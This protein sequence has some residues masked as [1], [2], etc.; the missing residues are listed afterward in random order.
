[1]INETRMNKGLAEALGFRPNPSYSEPSRR[2][3]C[4][5]PGCLFRTD[6]RL[7]LSEH[8]REKNHLS[9]QKNPLL[10]RSSS[11][12]LPLTQCGY[13]NCDFASKYLS[14]LTRHRRRKNHFTTENER[15]AAQAELKR[16]ELAKEMEKNKMSAESENEATSETEVDI[17]IPLAKNKSPSKIT[18]Y[19]KPRSKKL[20]Q[21]SQVDPVK[22]TLDFDDAAALEEE[23]TS[24][25]TKKT[26]EESDLT[27]ENAKKTTEVLEQ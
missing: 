3:R 19:F 24:S 14:N 1:M 16:D 4:G 17:T 18:D 13:D 15:D 23:K 5:N 27:V 2:F 25:D 6:S 9:P 8:R 26:N 22:K 11:T 10:S 12:H 7:K 21:K 20:P